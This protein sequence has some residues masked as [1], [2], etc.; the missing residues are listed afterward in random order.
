MSDERTYDVELTVYDSET[1][2]NLEVYTFESFN[3]RLTAA[4]YWEHLIR[5]IGVA[6]QDKQTFFL[7]QHPPGCPRIKF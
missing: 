4:D 5:I 7:M 6:D 1:G 2:D 3:D